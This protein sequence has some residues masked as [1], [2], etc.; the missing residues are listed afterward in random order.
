MEDKSQKG[1]DKEG[2][3]S[4]SHSLRNSVPPHPNYLPFSQHPTYYTHI[5]LYS[6]LS[7]T[8]STDINHLTALWNTI[9]NRATDIFHYYLKV[10]FI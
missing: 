2:M 6:N 7:I 10:L 8:F 9:S 4:M 1:P 5:L 3:K